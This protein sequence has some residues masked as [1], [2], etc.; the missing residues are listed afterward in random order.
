M[1]VT[2]LGTAAAEGIPAVWCECET[3]RTAR[4]RGGK[5]LRRRCAYAVDGDTMIDFGPDAIWQTTEFGIDPARL[6]RIVFTHNHGDHLSPLEFLF[7]RAPWFSQVSRQL[8]VIGSRR[9]FSRII[10]F[11][12][13]DTGIY[14]LADLN[15]RPVEI[16]NGETLRDGDLNITALAADHAPGKEA[17]LFILERGG[18]RFFVANDTGLLGEQGWEQLRGIALDLVAIDCT[19]GTGE[20]DLPHGHL[21]VNTVVQFRDRLRE[22]GCLGAKS[23]VFANHFSHNGQCAHENLEKIFAPHGIEVAWDGL[24]VSL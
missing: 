24:T 20:A 12:A 7:R 6:D 5:N 8:T 4:E 9:I 13:E 17:Q 11:A 10:S 19:M 22:L 18:K 1:K 15:I 16:S 21:G 3:C 14:D 2:F 23:R